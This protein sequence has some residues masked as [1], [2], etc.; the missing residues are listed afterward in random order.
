MPPYTK[1]AN[2]D[3]GLHAQTLQEIACEYVTSCKQFKKSPL[4]WRKSGGVRRSLGWIPVNTGAASW[5]NGQVYHNS[6]YFKMW[7]SYGLSQYRFR[8]GSY[9]DAHALEV[10]A[11]CLSERPVMSLGPVDVLS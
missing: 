5:R 1:G 2:K 7:D 4:N 11:H 10:I 3:L 9:E 8:S 6:H